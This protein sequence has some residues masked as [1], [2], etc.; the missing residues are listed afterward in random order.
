MIK[1]SVDEGHAFDA[2][3]IAIVKKN[4][5][6]SEINILNFLS[7]ENEI[8]NQ[9]G[10]IYHSIV[11]SNYFLNLIKINNDIFDAVDLVKDD[12][13]LGSVVDKLNYQR[14]LAKKEIQTIYF[15]NNLSEQ[16]IG[17]DK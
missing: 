10:E 7:L 9:V 13:I 8:K 12:K 15:N 17:Y 16:K 5:N 6:N 14:F 2:L 1:I 11:N 4:K 3:S